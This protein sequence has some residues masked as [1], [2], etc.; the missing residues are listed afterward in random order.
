MQV[1]WRFEAVYNALVYRELKI[2]VIKYIRGAIVLELKAALSQ[3][4]LF[5]IQVDCGVQV[6]LE[7]VRSL[8]RRIRKRKNKEPQSNEFSIFKCHPRKHSSLVTMTLSQIDAHSM[9]L[10]GFTNIPTNIGFTNTPTNIPSSP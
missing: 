6:D 9:L 3:T 5:F 10:S 2:R 8:R 7:Q 1:V 4:F